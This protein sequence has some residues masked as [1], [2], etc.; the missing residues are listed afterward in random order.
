MEYGIGRDR[1]KV[2]KRVKLTV[3]KNEMRFLE[4]IDNGFSLESGR[5]TPENRLPVVRR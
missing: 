5:T 2:G 4:K 1:L 3:E